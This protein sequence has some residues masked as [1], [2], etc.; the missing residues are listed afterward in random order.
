MFGVLLILCLAVMGGAIAYI[1]DR[2][3]MKIGKKRLTIW[4]LRPKH[5]SILITIVT[6]IFIAG[7]TLLLLTA[8][9]KDVRTALFGMEKL[10]QELVSL[11][12]A[13]KSKNEELSKTQTQYQ[14]LAKQIG[15]K[16]KS[17]Q[18]VEDELRVARQERDRQATLLAR[19]EGDIGTLQ[20]TKAA[21]DEKIVGLEGVREKLTGEVK[22]KEI[23]AKRLQLG[24]ENIREGNIALQ[25]G[26]ELASAVI[27]VN[28]LDQAKKELE[29]LIIQASRFAVANGAKA[30]TENTPVVWIS[31]YQYGEVL[32]FLTTSKKQ[33]VVRLISAANT[34]L[35]E[36]VAASFQLFENKK[37][38]RQGEMILTDKI[39]GNAPDTIIEAS[40]F[41]MLQKVNA[42]AIK[43]GMVPDILQG[44]IGTISVKDVY[45]LVDEIKQYQR[46]VSVSVTALND[47]WTADS[48]NIKL[49]VQE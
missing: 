27:Q 17:L 22:E 5:T 2:L 34:V 47:T 3:G 42:A 23:L 21:L 6:G 8:I 19:A 10:K 38:F 43:K 24:L 11:N 44:T 1:G 48:L 35:H 46:E 29:K 20:K 32:N 7:A 26:E 4:G 49:S 39:N 28:N 41:A 16:E 15:E 14:Q 9:S 33:M 25:T 45:T 12:G 40:V 13:V 30:Y 31:K 18:A 37:I 36:P